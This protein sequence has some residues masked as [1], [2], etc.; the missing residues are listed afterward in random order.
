MTFFGDSGQ[1]CSYWDDTSI[2]EQTKHFPQWP[3]IPNEKKDTYTD[4]ESGRTYSTWSFN[5]KNLLP[6]GRCG[7]YENRPD[8]CRRFEP[9]SG[10]LCVHYMG[11]EGTGDG[12]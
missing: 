12:L 9:A 8:L 11:A 1:E 3:F 5:C 4:A 7:D 2:E 10:P 6:N